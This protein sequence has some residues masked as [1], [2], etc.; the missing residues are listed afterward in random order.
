MKTSYTL[1]ELCR[2]IFSAGYQRRMQEVEDL[3]LIPAKGEPLLPVIVGGK[4][5]YPGTRAVIVVPPEAPSTRVVRDACQNNKRVIW[6]PQDTSG[7]DVTVNSLALEIEVQMMD[8]GQSV[9]SRLQGMPPPPGHAVWVKSHSRLK[10]KEIS[11]NVSGTN[12]GEPILTARGIKFDDHTDLADAETLA[13]EVR[14]LLPLL[15]ANIYYEDDYHSQDPETLSF[16]VLHTL[17]DVLRLPNDVHVHFLSTQNTTQRLIELKQLI[18]QIACPQL[19]KG[20]VLISSR[21]TPDFQFGGSVVLLYEHDAEGT[22]GVI[23]NQHIGRMATVLYPNGT[24]S[25][26]N[27]KT[28]MTPSLQFG[29]PVN[30]GSGPPFTQVL[31]R[32]VPADAE[33]NATEIIPGVYIFPGEHLQQPNYRSS[34]EIELTD[35]E[36]DE[37]S[38][39]EFVDGDDEDGEGDETMGQDLSTQGAARFASD[40]LGNRMPGEEDETDQEVVSDEAMASANLSATF[41][42]EN[43]HSPVRPANSTEDWDDSIVAMEGALEAEDSRNADW[44]SDE[45]EAMEYSKAQLWM[46]S[47]SYESSGLNTTENTQEMLIHGFAAWCPLQLDREIRTG[48]W[49]ICED[50]TATEIFDMNRTEVYEHVKRRSALSCF[51]SEAYSA[52]IKNNS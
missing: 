6:I 11:R 3:R 33:G 49:F 17:D 44:S 41:A 16:T 31:A 13:T 10:L 23:I 21:E 38:E 43:A 39:I 5:I 15:L 8:M 50:I 52:W 32:S 30:L 35:D 18:K 48:I 2:N 37:E 20:I 47:P 1:S 46:A 25:L 27:K 24:Q 34:V 19:R 42:H 40:S 7:S 9:A 36:D 51:D 4:A 22:K 12:Q 14:A 26:L 45:N 28:N 29:G